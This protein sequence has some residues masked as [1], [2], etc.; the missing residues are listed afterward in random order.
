MAYSSEVWQG[1]E[2]QSLEGEYHT[3]GLSRVDLR[4]KGESGYQNLEDVAICRDH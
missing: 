4:G 3:L 1:L 2:N